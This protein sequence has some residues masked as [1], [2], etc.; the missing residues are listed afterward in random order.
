MLNFKM[1]S[2]DI[3]LFEKKLVT[4]PTVLQSLVREPRARVGMKRKL[5]QA[6]ARKARVEA[7]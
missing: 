5:R 4:L 2:V 7:Y 6:D 1:Q 3:L